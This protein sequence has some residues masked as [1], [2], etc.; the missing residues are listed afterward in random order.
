M[1]ARGGRHLE[2]HEVRKEEYVC[3]YSCAGMLGE[4]GEGERKG[5]EKRERE[6]ETESV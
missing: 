1:R 4:G 3:V 2:E 6:R 5:E